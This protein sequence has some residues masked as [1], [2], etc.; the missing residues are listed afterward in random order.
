[1][2][3][4]CEHFSV[5]TFYQLSNTN[6]EMQHIAYLQVI[7]PLCDIG[8][9][10]FCVI[11]QKL[12]ASGSVISSRVF[13]CFF[14]FAETSNLQISTKVRMMKDKFAVIPVKS[15]NYKVHSRHEN[16]SRYETKTTEEFLF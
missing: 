1:V 6:H 8:K 14:F 11:L 2:D 16:I 7:F 15:T 5:H 9:V 4:N 13:F 3:C 10:C 12:V